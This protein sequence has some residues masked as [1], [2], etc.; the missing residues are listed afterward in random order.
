[1]KN[2]KTLILL[3]LVAGLAAPVLAETVKAKNF[4]VIDATVFTPVLMEG[5][6]LVLYD[7]YGDGW[8]GGKLDVFVNGSQ[9]YDD[10]TMPNGYT[11]TYPMNLEL[12]DVVESIYTA[13]AWSYEN[14]YAYYDPNGG[15]LASAPNASMTFTVAGATDPCD[16]FVVTPLTLPVVDLTGTTVG[17]TNWYGST[18]PD[19]IFS[20]VATGCNDLVIS[21]CGSSYDTYLYLFDGEV[22]CAQGALVGNLL[23]SNDDYCGLQ[24]EIHWTTLPGNTYTVA[25]GGYSSYSGSYILN[26]YCADVVDA[27]EQP[28]AFALAQNVPNPFNPTTTISFSMDETSFASLKVF[29]LAGRTVAS[30]VNGMVE[31][32]QHSVTLDASSLTSGVYFY[33]LEANGQVET[34]KMVLMK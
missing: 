23:M 25:V 26:I 11:I 7:S 29:D 32:G 3:S 33:A 28:A 21:L 16:G 8:N 19:E 27:N 20:F 30:L 12:G 24:S 1:M 22:S 18:A 10:I 14:S 5:Y 31:R 13:G 9:V 6:T 34:R 17:G 15:L 4:E 2:V